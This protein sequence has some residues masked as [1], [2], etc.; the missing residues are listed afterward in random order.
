M[1]RVVRA[2]IKKA[3]TTR[4]ARDVLGYLFSLWSH[5]KDGRRQYF[6]PGSDMIAHKVGCSRKTV[7]RAMAEFRDAGLLVVVGCPTGGKGCARYRMDLDALFAFCGVKMP[8][9]PTADI[10]D[11]QLF[12]MQKKDTRDILTRGGIGNRLITNENAYISCDGRERDEVPRIS[13]LGSPFQRNEWQGEDPMSIPIPGQGKADVIE[14]WEI[15][16]A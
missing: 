11:L 14:N 3:P 4:A 15:A 10:V 16:H 9:L 13:A 2:A 7:T 8:E 5:H 12:R 6:D 1:R